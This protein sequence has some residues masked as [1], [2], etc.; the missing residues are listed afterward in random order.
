VSSFLAPL[1]EYKR[2]LPKGERFIPPPYPTDINLDGTV[3]AEDLL[4]LLEDWG[5]VSGVR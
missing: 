3:D 1:R 5:R 4:I 2:K